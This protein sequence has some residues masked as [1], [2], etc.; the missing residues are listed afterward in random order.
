M[1]P[2]SRIRHVVRRRGAF[3][4]STASVPTGTSPTSSAAASPIVSA[5]AA[6]CATA[7]VAASAVASAAKPGA[8]D[9]DPCGC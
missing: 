5:V 7:A 4:I 8:A 3:A 6:P 2:Q 9:A 1:H